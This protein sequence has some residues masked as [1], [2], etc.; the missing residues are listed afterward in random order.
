MSY[1]IRVY[2]AYGALQFSSASDITRHFLGTYSTGT[3]DGSVSI[4]GAS[5][6]S[7][8]S[9]MFAKWDIRISGDTVSWK[10][11]S[12]E[13]RVSVNIDVFGSV[14]PTYTSY[15]LNII[16]ADGNLSV[17]TL[18]PAYSYVRKG[19]GI[20]KPLWS[21]GTNEMT[22]A[23]FFHRYTRMRPEA[24]SDYIISRKTPDEIIAI[25]SPNGNILTGVGINASGES[26]F[27]V[28]SAESVNLSYDY[29]VFSRSPP[30]TTSSPYGVFT[31]NPQGQVVFSSLYPPMRVVGSHVE[32]PGRS[33][34]NFFKNVS[35]TAPSG[36]YAVA[37]FDSG[38]MY[39]EEWTPPYV[40]DSCIRA[41]FKT[42]ATG[43]TFSNTKVGYHIPISVTYSFDPSLTSTALLLDVSEY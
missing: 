22:Q 6:I 38:P 36:K 7:I 32:P 14:T 31:K 4:P 33:E 34:S 16:G 11:T 35:I 25:A 24:A 19:V 3:V 26:V 20:A 15:G 37:V 23:A 9:H 43:A 41:V 29:Y 39:T 17:G 12:Q 21:G 8:A 18:L 10:W 40:L 30:Q 27:I 28:A 5:N 13:N 1:G 42:S 2:N